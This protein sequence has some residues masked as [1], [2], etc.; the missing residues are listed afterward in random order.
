M[1]PI[2]VV[3]GY[4]SEGADKTVDDIYANFPAELRKIFGDSSVVELDL[5]RWISLND[6]ICLDDVSFA[7]DRAL[8]TAYPQLLSDGFH[9]V[10]HST[11][12]LVVRNWI[13]K[14][15]PKP[16]PVIN[17]VHL[18]G[19]N[20]GSGLAH[21]GQGQLARWGRELLVGTGSGYRI[22]TE[23]EFGSWKT[24]D[25]HLHFLEDGSRMYDDYDVREFCIN[26]SQV[27]KLMRIAPIRY[28]R[29][30]SSDCT[31]RTSGCNLNF[32]YISIKPAKTAYSL[33]PKKLAGLVGDRMDGKVI[34]QSY[35]TVDKEILT[36]SGSYRKIPFSIPYEI[37]HSGDELGIVTGK[38]NRAPLLKLISSALKTDPDN[39]ADY[40]R[41]AKEFSDA[42][43]KT[44]KRIAKRSGLFSSWNLHG[45]YEGHAQLIFRIRDQEG[46]PVE[47]FDIYMKSNKKKK[48]DVA[49]ADLI[50][51]RHANGRDKGTM[52]FYLRTQEF[53]GKKDEWKELL[54]HVIPLD[55]EVTGEEPKSD[56]IAYVP[57]RVRLNPE[58]I[59]SQLK[60]FQTTIVDVELL[61][62]PSA[63][64]FQIST[65]P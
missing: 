17:F 29:E 13:K 34:S 27:P 1:K 21:I 23:L 20:F 53:N 60:S 41:V 63:K 16:S 4:S 25:L 18:A 48:T 37:A 62:L 15:S 3:H 46:L 30:D 39:P 2:L 9:V 64:V 22:L 49:L 43:D 47:H 33:S 44:F 61:R 11:G 10:I 28:V 52:T 45:Q 58:Q 56:D 59:R 31:V 12:A 6:G 55:L 57:L 5:S 7:M 26:G 36:D 54:D 19:A 42:K 50:E 51:N 65:A 8:R 38:K 40:V 24:L 14:F 35:Y 32:N